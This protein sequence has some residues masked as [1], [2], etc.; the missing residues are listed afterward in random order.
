[1]KYRPECY[2]EP[3]HSQELR[4]EN[5]EDRSGNKMILTIV[6][7]IDKKGSEKEQIVQVKHL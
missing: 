2:R 3:N 5:F 6:K 1:M 7:Y 4:I